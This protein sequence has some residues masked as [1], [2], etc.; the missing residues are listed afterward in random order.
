MLFVALTEDVAKTVKH[1]AILHVS[2]DTAAV[3]AHLLIVVMAAWT[4]S[5]VHIFTGKYNNMQSNY[6]TPGGKGVVLPEIGSFFSLQVYD[7]VSPHV[8]ESRTVLDSG[9]QSLGGF[10]IP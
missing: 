2:E 4:E 7:I 6:L 5:V 8:K 9:L 3:I 1:A 10:R